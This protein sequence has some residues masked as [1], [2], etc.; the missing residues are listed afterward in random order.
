MYKFLC[1]HQSYHYKLRTLK[2]CNA[3]TF[4]DDLLAF[5]TGAGLGEQVGYQKFFIF[6]QKTNH[7]SDS[8]QPKLRK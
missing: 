5:L 2:P 6:S 3:S 1:K 8:H 7:L 4:R